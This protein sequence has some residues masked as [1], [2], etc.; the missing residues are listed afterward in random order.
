MEPHAA[1]AER[2]LASILFA[3]RLGFTTLAQDRDP[4]VVREL[5]SRFGL[6]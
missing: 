4:E 1:C 3:D 2:R 5:L 6:A